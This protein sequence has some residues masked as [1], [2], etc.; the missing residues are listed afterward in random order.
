MKLFNCSFSISWEIVTT[1][2]ILAMPGLETKQIYRYWSSSWCFALENF[3]QSMCVGSSLNWEDRCQIEI[4]YSWVPASPN[5]EWCFILLVQRRRK[6]S[7]SRTEEEEFERNEEKD[8]I[9][10][11]S[12]LCSLSLLS[13]LL[14]FLV[15]DTLEQTT[16]LWSCSSSL[17]LNERLSVV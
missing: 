12:F 2:E 6:C 9:D 3:I 4:I 10:G 1:S 16:P 5:R 17:W 14:L 7:C 15:Q 13:L 11:S 8:R